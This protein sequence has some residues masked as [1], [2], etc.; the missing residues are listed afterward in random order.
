METQVAAAVVATKTAVATVMEDAQTR[1]INN[2]R[3]AAV[4][5]ATKKTKVIATTTTTITMARAVA[6]KV[7]G[8]GGGPHTSRKLRGRG[9]DMAKRRV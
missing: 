3:K 1:K 9:E 5:T 8:G 4:A 6:V 2:Q 7:G